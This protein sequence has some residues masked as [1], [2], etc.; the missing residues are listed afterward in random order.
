MPRIE[1]LR[2]LQ[3]ILQLCTLLTPAIEATCYILT[4]VES[5]LVESFILFMAISSKQQLVAASTINPDKPINKLFNNQ[6]L[7]KI[8][9]AVR[10]LS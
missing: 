9:I 10:I 4:L 6:V 8:K 7:N 3:L 5:R 1:C 2:A